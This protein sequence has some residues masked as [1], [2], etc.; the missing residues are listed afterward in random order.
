VT[1]EGRLTSWDPKLGGGSMGVWALVATP[2]A[3]LVGGE[4]ITVNGLNRPRF[5]RFSGTP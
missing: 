4:F 1:L 5:A 2:T 3:V